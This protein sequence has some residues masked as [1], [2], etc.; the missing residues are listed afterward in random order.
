VTKRPLPRRPVRTGLAAVW[1]AA[2]LANRGGAAQ[3][4]PPPAQATPVPAAIEIEHQAPA[5][6]AAG[7][8]A[9]LDA[10][11][12]PASQLA[13]AR[14]YF[15]AFGT[16]DW[17]YVEMKPGT[18]CHKGTLPKPK[19]DIGRIEYYISAT[20]RRSSETRTKDATLLVTSDGRCPSGPLAPVGDGSGLVIG[21]LTG[22]AP[23]GFVAGGG[24]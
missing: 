7:Q 15:R 17:F 5:C 16:P 1:L 23:V 19:K 10:C 24:V 12:R 14:L 9:R 13:R 4:A 3:Q 22:G 8:Y 6:V 20:D 18:P 2:A 11:F 21:S